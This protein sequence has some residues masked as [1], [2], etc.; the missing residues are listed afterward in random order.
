MR[1]LVLAGVMALLLL[2]ALN[3]PWLGI[4]TWSWL[5]YMNPHRLTYG[6][7]YFFPWSMV[8]AVVM[9]VAVFVARER[10]RIPWTRETIVLLLFCVWVTVA[11]CF[12]LNP[13][14]A[15]DG[16]VR[17]I[18]I[19]FMIFATLA[20]MQ[21][22]QRLHLLVWVITLSLALFGVKGGMFAIVTAGAYRVEGPSNTFIGS[23]NQ[24][25]L[26]LVMTL[27]LMRYLQ[28]QAKRILVRTAIAGAMALTTLAI[29]STYSRG[30]VVAFCIVAGVMLWRSKRRLVTGILVV[31]ALFGLFA[32]MPE[33]W[34][35]RMHSTQNYEEDAS[36][37]GRFNAWRF[38]VNVANDRP[39]VGG[40]FQTFTWQ[41]FE[42]Y[43]PN[44][45][46]HHDA[47]SI[48]F[49]VLGEQGYVGL[50]L[51]LTLWI[52]T[53]LS[54]MWV[55][56]HA[57]EVPGMEWAHDMTSMV[58]VSLIGYLCGGA[59]SGLAYFDFP[60][61]LMTII[62]LAK[63]KVQ[64]AMR[65]AARVSW[66]QQASGAWPVPAVEGGTSPKLA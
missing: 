38:A 14:N 66:K 59:F 41:L 18:K 35:E 3:R 9:I 34:T 24:L 33:Q 17:V 1:D 16:W 23:N 46:D 27:P 55:L 63:V 47:H 48:Y 54:G 8:T 6:F 40:G 56:R 13:V 4:L 10:F 19:Q 2:F 49:E 12:A 31:F 57:K 21:D 37:Q 50:A 51:F 58:Q 36:A 26:A 62:V 42:I 60:Y 20:V 43:A 30:G 39:L 65:E 52:L 28:L 11:T 25:A 44:P 45:R 64:E 61:H 15:W 29:L 53:L 22:R 5:G 32:F 7:A